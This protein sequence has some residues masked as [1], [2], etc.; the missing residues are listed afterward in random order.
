MCRLLPLCLAL[1]PALATGA[2][3][4]DLP[5]G[6]VARLGSAVPPAGSESRPGDVNALAFIGDEA[7]FVGTS[8]GWQT[9]DVQ[10]RQPRQ[11]RPTG[12]PAFAA[13]R[14][15][16]QLFVGSARRVHVIEPVQSATAEPARS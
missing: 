8:S 7:I 9:W 15:A 5:K 16:D 14:R 2:P 13:F 4:N 11:E 3:R 12:G 1:F 10:K 6:A